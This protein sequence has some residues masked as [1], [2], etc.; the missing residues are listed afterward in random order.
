MKF[1]VHWTIPVGRVRE[2]YDR[3]RTQGHEEGA[4][5]EVIGTSHG[6]DHAGGW[7]VV[8]APDEQAIGRWLYHWTD[9]NAFT[10]TPVVDDGGLLQLIGE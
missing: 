9:L 5:V 8:D 3:L 1:M 4:G 10:V 6:L 7:A 2:A